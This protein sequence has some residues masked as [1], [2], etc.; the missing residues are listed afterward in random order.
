[1]TDFSYGELLRMGVAGTVLPLNA[2]SFSGRRDETVAIE[3]ELVPVISAGESRL[4]VRTELRK[5]LSELWSS[6]S[7]PPLIVVSGPET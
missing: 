3:D 7:Q 6:P 2:I 4:S 5:S 1:V